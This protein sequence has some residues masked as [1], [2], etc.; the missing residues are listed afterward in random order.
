[1]R[2]HFPAEFVFQIFALLI[3]FIVVHAVYTAVIRPRASAFLDEQHAQ[4]KIDADYS[5]QRSIYVVL[6]DY[7]QE[8]CFVLMF[9][10]I[11]IIVF[12]WVATY[13]HQRQLEWDF[14]GL[15]E[16]VP[17][18]VENSAIISKRIRE[19]VPQKKQAYLLPTVLLSTIDRYSATRSILEAS[20]VVHAMC[21]SEAERSES[22]LSMIRYIAW[23]IPS[24]GFIGTVRGIGDALAQAHKAVGGDITG[25][26]ESL[27]V[28]FNSTLIALLISLVL[29]FFIHQ[30]QLMQERLVHSVE[31]Y[32]QNMFIRRLKS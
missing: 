23:A 14:I 31:K 32:C 21:E 6:R 29:M 20:T 18:S 9:W 10:A 1:M 24:V 13:R 5:P 2:K 27:G 26:T 30:I 17:I 15:P 8:V 4:M 28:A 19:E 7:E 16:N 3:V 11:A 25:V 12:K 22:E